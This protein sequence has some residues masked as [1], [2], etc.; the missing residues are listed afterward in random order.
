MGGD[1]VP[2]W[3]PWYWVGSRGTGLVPVV[4]GRR[5]TINNYFF[6]F[7]SVFELE[8]ALTLAPCNQSYATTH[9]DVHMHI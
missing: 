7:L 4:P 9:L 5:E 2:G 3:F 6:L 1:P 8:G